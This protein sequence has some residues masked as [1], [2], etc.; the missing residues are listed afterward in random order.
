MPNS[1]ARTL[2]QCPAVREKN[3]CD[4]V[5]RCARTLA[6]R[7]ASAA[8]A[9]IEGSFAGSIVRELVGAEILVID[10]DVRALAEV[11]D[12]HYVLEKGR[13]V[14]SG[15]SAELRANQEVQHKYL[16]V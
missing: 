9:R 6:S 5:R 16:G 1:S 3:S 2:S 8:A 11:A 13:V 15:G 10:K 14:W 12:V 7:E 4:R